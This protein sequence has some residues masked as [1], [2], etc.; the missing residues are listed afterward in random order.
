FGSNLAGQH[1]AG[2]ARTALE[3]FGAVMGVGRGWSGQSY[4]IPTMN[5]H[6]QQ[7]P[8]SQIQHYIDDFK[9]Y[10]KNHSKNKYFITSLGCG[11]AGLKSKKLHRCLKV[12]HAMSFSRNLFALLW[13]SLYPN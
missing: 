9:I 4:A 6:L 13:K 7:M 10:T 3:H 1:S 5:E 12:F 8:L 2:A 11:I